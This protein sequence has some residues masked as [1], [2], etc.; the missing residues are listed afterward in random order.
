MKKIFVILGHPNKE[1]FCGELF[2]AY[3]RGAK[4]AGH[5]VRETRIGD[6]RFDPILHKGH[7]EIQPLEPDLKKAQ[8]DIIWAEHVVF[9]FP[10]W[11][12]SFP[13]LLKGF[14]DRIFLPGFGFKYRK[15][16]SLFRDKLLAG[17]SSRVIITMDA[18]VWY[19][20]LVYG[21]SGWIAFKNGILKFC[22]FKRVRGTLIGRLRFLSE[23]KRKKWINRIEAMG[24]S[25]K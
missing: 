21:A 1:S 22:G 17:R 14:I 11:W 13:A 20:Y 7:K 2:D 25:G 23:N 18:P 19:Y 8:E 5:E 24:K 16:N 12:A 9:I 4:T 6:L 15:K 3:V 10:T